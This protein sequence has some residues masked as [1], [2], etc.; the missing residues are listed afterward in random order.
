[1]RERD[2]KE[3]QEEGGGS[4]GKEGKGGEVRVLGLEGW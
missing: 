3:R 2:R 4:K 1:M